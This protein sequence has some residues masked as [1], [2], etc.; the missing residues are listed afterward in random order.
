MFRAIF[1]SIIRSSRLYIQQQA[2][3]KQIL[4]SACCCMYSLELL[5][6]DVTGPEAPADAIRNVKMV[7]PVAAEELSVLRISLSPCNLSDPEI[8]AMN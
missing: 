6:M 4:L 8:S 2:F 5:L 3:V 7:K 1:P